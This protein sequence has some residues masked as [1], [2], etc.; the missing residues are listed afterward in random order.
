MIQLNKKQA[1]ITAF[2]VLHIVFFANLYYLLFFGVKTNAEIHSKFGTSEES[3]N[4]IISF[5]YNSK[6]YE[7]TTN[8]DPAIQRTVPIIFS[9]RNPE[10]L[11]PLTFRNMFLG[12]ITMSVL[13]AFG[14]LLLI[15][16]T[17][18]SFVVFT[19][20]FK[21]FVIGFEERKWNKKSELKLNHFLN[22]SPFKTLPF[23]YYDFKYRFSTLF[24]GLYQS[25]VK[26]HYTLGN[27]K[28]DSIKTISP[29]NKTKTI[30]KTI[31]ELTKPISEIENLTSIEQAVL[32]LFEN[33]Q[34]SP[35]E[36]KLKM[37]QTFGKE[38]D[39]LNIELMNDYLSTVPKEAKIRLEELHQLVLFIE[40]YPKQLIKLKPN[41]LSQLIFILGDN[42]QFLEQKTL[43][44]IKNSDLNSETKELAERHLNAIYKTGFVKK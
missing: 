14:F 17:F 23:V 11:I 25:I 19:I 7:I 28:T 34:F 10:N 22:F 20:R 13:F 5:N 3:S 21:P 30:S 35:P 15:H 6:S 36:F 24:E 18:K 38:Y 26:H 27:I 39:K 9:E 8:I 32:S 31:L 16:V 33:Q 44:L 42:L 29:R 12:R 4:K 2:L 1:I 41:E 43:K 40:T 37:Q